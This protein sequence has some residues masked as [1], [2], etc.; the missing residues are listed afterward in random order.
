[1]SIY[2]QQQ[3]SLSNFTVSCSSLSSINRSPTYTTITNKPIMYDQHHLR[4]QAFRPVLSIMASLIMLMTIYCDHCSCSPS[5]S[6]LF[7]H[8]NSNSNQQKPSSYHM[9]MVNNGRYENARSLSSNKRFAIASPTSWTSTRS[10]RIQKTLMSMSSP[11]YQR[12]SLR[13]LN[14]KSNLNKDNNLWA[15]ESRLQLYQQYPSNQSSHIK[16]RPTT[17]NT[18]VDSMESFDGSIVESMDRVDDDFIDYDEEENEMDQDIRSP[19]DQMTT[20]NRMKPAS[21][22]LR[23]IEQI[24]SYQM[25]DDMNETNHCDHLLAYDLMLN[26]SINSPIMEQRIIIESEHLELYLRLHPATNR[27]STVDSSTS[28]SMVNY[29]NNGNWNCRQMLQAQLSSTKSAIFDLSTSTFNVSCYLVYGPQFQC[30]LFTFTTHHFASILRSSNQKEQFCGMT[31]LKF[32][33]LDNRCQLSLTVKQISATVH[34]KSGDNIGH[35]LIRNQFYQSIPSSIWEILHDTLPTIMA[36]STNITTT[37]EQSSSSSGSTVNCIR[38]CQTIPYTNYNE[39]INRKNPNNKSHRNKPESNH[40]LMVIENTK[41]KCIVHLDNRNVVNSNLNLNQNQAAAV[42]NHYSIASIGTTAGMGNSGL[43]VAS[44]L[45]TPQINEATKKTCIESSKH[46]LTHNGLVINH[47]TLKLIITRPRN[48]DFDPMEKETLQ[49]LEFYLKLE[50]KNLASNAQYFDLVLKK[51]KWSASASLLYPEIYPG[52]LTGQTS[53]PVESAHHHQHHHGHHDHDRLPNVYFRFIFNNLKITKWGYRYVLKITLRSN[54]ACY[55]IETTFGPFNVRPATDQSEQQPFTNDTNNNDVHFVWTTEKCHSVRINLQASIVIDRA[56]QQVIGGHTNG[57]A[58]VSRFIDYLCDLNMEKLNIFLINFLANRAA[59][60]ASDMIPSVVKARIAMQ[61]SASHRSERRRLMARRE[62]TFTHENDHARL[63]HDFIQDNGFRINGTQ[64][65]QMLFQSKNVSM[66]HHLDRKTNN[67]STPAQSNS[68]QEQFNRYYESFAHF[69]QQQLRQRLINMTFIYSGELLLKIKQIYINDK[70]LYISPSPTSTSSGPKKVHFGL[71]FHR[72][73]KVVD[74][75]KNLTNRAVEKRKSDESTSTMATTQAENSNNEDEVEYLGSNNN[76]GSMTTT[77]PH[78]TRA[79]ASGSNLNRHA[80]TV[81]PFMIDD[82]KEHQFSNKSLIW[83]LILF[84]NTLLVFG[85]IILL[86]VCYYRKI[87]Y[88]TTIMKQQQQQ[89]SK[90]ADSRR[91]DDDPASVRPTHRDDVFMLGTKDYHPTSSGSSYSS[92]GSGQH[93][94]SPPLGFRRSAFVGAG[95]RSL[96]DEMIY[97]KAL[98][99]QALKVQHMNRFIS[100]AASKARYPS[101]LIIMAILNNNV[102]HKA[103]TNPSLTM[104][105]QHEQKE[106]TATDVLNNEATEVAVTTVPSP[107]TITEVPVKEAD[108][109]DD[110]NQHPSI[111]IA[112]TSPDK[113]TLSLPHVKEESTK[114][115]RLEEIETPKPIVVNYN[116][117]WDLL[118][119]VSPSTSRSSNKIGSRN[120]Q[121]RRSS[122][123]PMANGRYSTLSLA[124]DE[125]AEDSSTGSS[126]S[127]DRTYSL[128]GDENE[129]EKYFIYKVKDIN[130]VPRKECVGKV[131]VPRDM[132][133]GRGH[134]IT[135]EEFRKLIRQSS[136]EM[137]REAARQR[138]KYLAESYHLVASTQESE[139]P[140]RQMYPAQG[141]FIKLDNEPYP[142]RREVDTSWTAKLQAEYERK[143]GPIQ[144]SSSRQQRKRSS[145]SPAQLGRLSRIQEEDKDRE[146]EEEEENRNVWDPKR[147]IQQTQRRR[148]STN[149][150]APLAMNVYDNKLSSTYPSRTSAFR[151]A[152]HMG[153]YDWFQSQPATTSTSFDHRYG[154]RRKQPVARARYKGGRP[155]WRF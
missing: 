13:P 110:K 74:F 57:H 146:C 126:D 152:N 122:L 55:T 117:D 19:D 76:Q 149:R 25:T 63:V 148:N 3:S 137:L 9:M 116:E 101:P 22:P 140:V 10:D 83:I 7:I 6:S 105:P 46:V 144:L 75:K 142:W 29:D 114:T 124:H 88:D 147:I 56:S 79:K 91:L 127:L 141:V 113:Q 53:V 27:K 21:M 155:P 151:T 132:F 85:F 109:N 99:N 135:L 73:T 154:Q 70:P 20:M 134:N 95:E 43:S 14:R 24:R 59:T 58:P 106:L 39:R 103:Q 31:V 28:E 102:V 15:S 138:F 136:D 143:F 90:M 60:T 47:P 119:P 77:K 150:V 38:L 34:H 8:S 84:V 51:Y 26:H 89:I 23:L 44:S 118:T 112:T 2:G 5:S 96:V 128:R 65:L 36:A 121:R 94:S 41:P 1:M 107:I 98:K 30:V 69:Q 62:W 17:A 133:G 16:P 11:Y 120:R 45:A 92:Y 64:C 131:I 72:K 153:K 4:H 12:K 48:E 130:L 82:D 67:K 54:P 42:S 71:G 61:N 145:I 111:S 66:L 33:L 108:S 81:G 49:P 35:R 87:I 115:E 80:T 68:I 125:E 37:N 93:S 78:R 32:N 100:S 104:D 139:T 129:D 18:N 40:E 86:A 97:E 50:S 52:I 123:R